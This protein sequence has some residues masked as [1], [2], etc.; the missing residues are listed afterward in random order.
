MNRTATKRLFKKRSRLS[1]ITTYAAPGQVVSASE[2]GPSI[3]AK[4]IL[5][6]KQRY[7][8]HI[9]AGL[10]AVF[11]CWGMSTSIAYAD[12]CPLGGE[13]TYSVTIERPATE[14]EEG[15]KH[16]LCTKCGYEFDHVV[17]ATGHS[18]S[19]WMIEVEPT[20]ASEGREYRQCDQYH[21]N[22][23]Y[24]ERTLPRLS[25][26]GDH[27]YV[28][29]VTNAP[30]CTELGY[31]TYTCEY[32]GGT[33]TE[34]VAALGHAWGAWVVETEATDKHAGKEYRA[35]AND[36]SHIEYQALPQ[37]EKQSEDPKREE[38]VEEVKK[39]LPAPTE[40]KDPLPEIESLGFF[41]FKPNAID[42][43]IVGIDIAV[44]ALFA[45]LLIPFIKRVRWT[46]RKTQE[47]FDQYV[48]ELAGKKEAENE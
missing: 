29:T 44:L 41:S 42:A 11:V 6:D 5:S 39:P 37:L 26:T 7:L 33:Y 21:D 28:A 32:C 30:T 4:E 40:S 20:C 38:V 25:P 13:H 17:A 22:I 48:K 9:I 16:F 24:E 18:W 36:A 31:I 35:C 14:F 8:L 3:F 27:A 46:D 43:A 34:E 23:H 1:E 19:P 47:A 45:F 15:L 12:E 2:R 10:I